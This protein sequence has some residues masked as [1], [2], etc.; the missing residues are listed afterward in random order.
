VGKRNSITFT[1]N[2]GRN[3][4]KVNKS[5][6]VF[7]R[8]P[9]I[10]EALAIKCMEKAKRLYA[11]CSNSLIQCERFINEPRQSGEKSSQQGTAPLQFVTLQ[12][13]DEWS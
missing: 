1:F 3:E 2:H 6:W 4:V 5:V 9:E 12:Q 8:Y 10:T 13:T 7:Q 11:M